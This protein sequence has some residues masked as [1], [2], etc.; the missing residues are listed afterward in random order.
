MFF[1]DDERVERL[2]RLTVAD[3]VQLGA[4][5]KQLGSIVSGRRG[6]AFA[7]VVIVNDDNEPELHFVGWNPN[8]L[9]AYEMARYA[10]E[11]GYALVDWLHHRPADGETGDEFTPADAMRKRWEL[12]QRAEMVGRQRD[13]E[14]RAELPWRCEFCDRG[15]R[16]ETGAVRHESRCLA[17]P[18][19]GH[20][21]V[22]WSWQHPA[23]AVCRCRCGYAATTSNQVP[24]RRSRNE[25]ERL[26]RAHFNE[27]VVESDG[28]VVIGLRPVD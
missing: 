17:S 20:G 13:I 4:W 28:D 21:A 24:Q 9:S 26:M 3:S 25:L 10:N 5:F 16:T 2:K 27:H 18:P 11:A 8:R 14:K 19:E 22:S 7:I 6:D 23:E 15:Y 12:R 1:F